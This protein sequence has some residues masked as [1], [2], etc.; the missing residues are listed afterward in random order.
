MS[1]GPFPMSADGSPLGAGPGGDA[2]PGRARIA[3]TG[4]RIMARHGVLPVEHAEEQPFI[5]DAELVVDEPERDE[6]SRTVDYAEVARVIVRT[7]GGGHV[8]LIE[9]LAARIADACLVLPGVR[10]SAVRVH[11]PEAPIGLPF[12]DVSA[13]VVRRAGDGAGTGTTPDGTPA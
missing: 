6:L 1:D 12:R 10:A 7:V 5:V 2:V 4:L 3:L 8:D 13:T 9:T 11:K